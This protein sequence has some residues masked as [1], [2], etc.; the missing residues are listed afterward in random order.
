MSSKEKQINKK[1]DFIIN[2]MNFLKKY[3]NKT[4]SFEM[5]E[6]ELNEI[7]EFNAFLHRVIDTKEQE[8][9]RYESYRSKYYDLKDSLRSRRKKPYTQ[10][11]E[12]GRPLDKK[13][14]FPFV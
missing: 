8:I 7:K 14:Y 11:D 6:K 2:Q 1:I 4:K 9:K 3:Y 5:I 13:F 10:K 12:Y